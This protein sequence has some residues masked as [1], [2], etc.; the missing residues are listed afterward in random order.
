MRHSHSART[1]RTAAVVCAVAAWGAASAQAAD[2]PERYDT[3]EIT[4]FAGYAFGGEF[5]DPGDESE[6]D[7]E[8]DTAFGVIFDIAADE[9]RHYEFLYSNQSTEVDGAAPFDLDVQYLQ[10]GGIVSHPD[11]KYAIPYFGITVGGAQF[12][13]DASGL[14]TETKLAFTV[15]GGMRIPITDHIGVRFDA[16][17]FI[18]M[19]DTDDGEIFCVSAG[20]ATCSIRAKSDT[21]MQYA[22]SLGV[23]IGF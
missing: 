10:I 5:E 2:P 8:A 20:G 7:L 15:G 16:R 3:F 18:T 12:S 19:L 17:A 23:T 11:A 13:P 14:D 21:F 6:R 4:P 22:A 1:R 9:W